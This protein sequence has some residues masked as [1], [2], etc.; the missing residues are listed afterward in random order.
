MGHSG[1]L[2]LLMPPHSVRRLPLLPVFVVLLLQLL[3]GLTDAQFAGFADTRVVIL[4]SENS[5]LPARQAAF[6]SD[7][8]HE[9][10]AAYVHFDPD[11]RRGC[12]TTGF[13]ANVTAPWMALVER[14]DCTFIDKVRNMQVLGAS[15]VIVGDYEPGGLVTMFGSGD[16][17]DV[18]IP[19]VFVVKV[20]FDVLQ[21]QVLQSADRGMAV[22]LAPNET[23]DWPVVDIILVTVVAPLLLLLVVYILCR[24]C[25]TRAPEQPTHTTPQVI[26]ASLPTKI[27]YHAK[28]RENEPT[29]CVICLDEF[30]DEDELRVLPCNHMFHLVCVDQWL[31]ERRN[32]C[33]VCRMEIKGEEEEDDDDDNLESGRQHLLSDASDES[34]PADLGHEPVT[35]AVLG[36]G[37]PS[38]GTQPEL[39]AWTDDDGDEEDELDE[40]DGDDENTPLISLRPVTS[41]RSE[42]F[43]SQTSSGPSQPPLGAQAPNPSDAILIT[44]EDSLPS[45]ARLVAPRP[46]SV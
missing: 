3:L 21:S 9:G 30:Q 7:L 12:E 11:N 29:M 13:L 39:S 28:L 22:W 20:D 35:L 8:P 18:H 2:S 26:L 10:M 16:T 15:A 46:S 36:Q 40:E 14:G 32:C 5:T 33:P 41:D 1:P 17:T 38:A 23:A 34:D 19:S 37:V 6:G 25:T 42:A 44:S 31:I 24:V 43:H 45:P 4:A 27:F